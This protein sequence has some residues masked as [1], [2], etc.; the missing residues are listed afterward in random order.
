MFTLT[1][2]GT[3][4]PEDVE[5]CQEACLVDRLGCGAFTWDPAT[6]ECVITPIPYYHKGSAEKGMGPLSNAGLQ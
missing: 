1:R 4:D 5:A 6:G 2:P 3:S